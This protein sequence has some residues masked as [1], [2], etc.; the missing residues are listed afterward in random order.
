MSILSYVF[1]FLKGIVFGVANIIPGVSGGTMAVVMGIYDRLVEAIGGVLTD[2]KK[3]VS[4]II[5]LFVLGLGAIAGLKGLAPIITYSLDHHYELTMLFFMG[6]ITGSFPAVLKL[7]G[8]KKLTTADM[9]ALS[10]GIILVLVLGANEGAK[11]NARAMADINTAKL[12][13]SG[14]L[15][16]GAMIVPGVSGSLIMVLLGVYPVVLAAVDDSDYKLL[17]IFA[18]GVGLGILLFSLLMRV[19]LKHASNLTHSFIFGLVGASV[20]I[21]FSG[22]PEGELS[23][24]IGGA[25]FVVG[26]VIAFLS[27]SSEKTSS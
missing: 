13:I 7:S 25:T 16:G 8:I 10:V 14:V 12:V 3:R 21:L 1:L 27:G 4:H 5:F 9:V 11:E 6:L 15:A 24:L 22:F 17:A 19:L 20:V 23:W 18:I 2:G 26:A